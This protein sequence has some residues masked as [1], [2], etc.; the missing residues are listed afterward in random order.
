MTLCV[1]VFSDINPSSWRQGDALVRRLLGP[2]KHVRQSHSPPTRDIFTCDS[3]ADIQFADTDV[4]LAVG[5]FVPSS[6]QDSDVVP[7][8][9]ERSSVDIQPES[10][11]AS[12]VEHRS[13]NVD[14]V[15]DSN[16]AASSLH[17]PLPAATNSCDLDIQEPTIHHIKLR[18]NFFHSL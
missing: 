15:T 9:L 1:L 5:S 18:G 10:A 7:T 11:T 17:Q 8:E 2:V 12:L 16:N 13:N 14:E 6:V 3:S 4:K